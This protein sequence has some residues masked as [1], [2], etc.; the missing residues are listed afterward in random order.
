[1]ADVADRKRVENIDTVVGVSI[2][3]AF[4]YEV[5]GA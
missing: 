4:A 3:I 5:L 2:T 1:M